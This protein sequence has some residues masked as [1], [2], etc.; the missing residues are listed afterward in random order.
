MYADAL[1]A[2]LYNSEGQHAAHDAVAAAAYPSSAASDQDSVP[3]YFSACTTPPAMRRRIRKSAK[4]NDLD[5]YLVMDSSTRRATPI[6]AR[7]PRSARRAHAAHAGT[8][9]E[10]AQRLHTS[11]DSRTRVNIRLGTFPTG[12]LVNLF[13]GNTQLASRS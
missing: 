4:S 9:K 13:G 2:D 5:P 3:P 10:I 6:P 11:S 7:A 12:Q 1:Q 8:G